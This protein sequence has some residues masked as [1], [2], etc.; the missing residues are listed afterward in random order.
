MKRTVLAAA[1]LLLGVVLVGCTPSLADRSY[2]A[3]RD[4]AQKVLSLTFTV[5]AAVT[6][7][8][9]EA[10]ETSCPRCPHAKPPAGEAAAAAI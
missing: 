9:P 4:G 1:V 6:N 7:W 5:A 3:V 10:S 8:L 2:G